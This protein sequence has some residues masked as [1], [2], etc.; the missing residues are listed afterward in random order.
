[1]KKNSEFFLTRV[2]KYIRFSLKKFQS[3]VERRPFVSFFILLVLLLALIAV[4]N[5]FRRPPTE[6]KKEI[7]V[8]KA[9]SMYSIGAIP[10]IRLQAQVEK[11][12]V[13]TLTA[14]MAGVVQEIPVQEGETVARG[15][16]LLSLS[17]NYQGGNAL[18]LQRAIAQRQYENAK[19]TYDDELAVLNLQR[20]V[21]QETQDNAD[22]LREISAQSISG[23]QT[24]IDLNNVILSEI[25]PVLSYY[26]SLPFDPV[27]QQTVI[28]LLQQQAQVTS[29]NT[30]LAT[31]L[32]NVQYQTNE[33]NPPAELAELQESI[34]LA[35]LDIRQK[36]LALNREIAKL[37]LQIAQ[38]NE[39]LMYPAAPFAATVQK[40]FV[41]QGQAVQP[42]TPLVLISGL[43]EE[44]PI[45]AVLYVPRHIAQTISRV[46]PSRLF[47]G[48]FVYETVPSYVSTEAIS[49]TLYAVFYPVPETFTLDLTD[50]GYIIIETPIG[51]A[52]TSSVVPF[53]PIDSVY[54]TEDNA[55]VFVAR[56][57]TVEEKKVLLGTVVGEFVE[58]T[59]GLAE[60]DFV[61][62]DRNVI[63]GDRVTLR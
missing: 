13:I 62:L 10:K 34:T 54:Q 53:I 22:E 52:D 35:Q 30:Q 61:I 58:V 19:T 46:E 31:S 36:A 3:Q 7:K 1:M 16:N 39:A 18:T 45:T 27:T 47:L 4:S 55:Y 56:N 15:Q 60:G 11:S 38:V 59:A 8:V 40:V 57:G 41:R 33:D 12:S 25:A 17:T 48:N 32:K 26:Q 50:R 49:G 24:V 37:Q 21:A 5:L 6:P 44:D 28:G 20:K 14:Q 29:A 42:G 2:K 23:T 43:P 9:V 63:A 51:F